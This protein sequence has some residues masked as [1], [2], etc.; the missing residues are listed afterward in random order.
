MYIYI[1]VNIKLYM[2]LSLSLSL[3]INVYIEGILQY[4]YP[5]RFFSTDQGA[6]FQGHQG[7][8]LRRWTAPILWARTVLQDQLWRLP[9]KA[10]GGDDREQ[11]KN[12]HRY[13]PSIVLGKSCKDILEAC[14]WW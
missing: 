11:L 8:A 2:S 3:Y 12:H 13:R 4:L 1:Y 10:T 7:A 14:H 6:H 9:V 5:P